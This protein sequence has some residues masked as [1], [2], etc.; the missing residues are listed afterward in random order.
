MLNGIGCF[1]V[2]F[3]QLKQGSKPYQALPR[4][5]AYTLQKPFEEEVK[6]L[7]KQDIIAHLGVDETVEWCN[8]FVLV[9]KVTGTVRLCLDTAWLNKM[10]IR[11]VHR[12]PTLND[13][14]PRLNAKYLSLIDV[15][16]GYHNLKLD[17]RSSYLMTFRC[18]FGRYRYKQLPFGAAL[19][20]N[21]FQS[22]GDKIFKE[23]LIVFGIADDI[24]VVRYEND[25]KDHD[26]ILWRVLQICKQ[27]NLKLNKDKCH[28][29]CTSVPFFGEVISWHTVKQDPQK[30]KALIKMPSPQSKKELQTFHGIINYFD[31]FSPNTANVCELLQKLMSSKTL[32]T[33]NTSYQALFDKVKSLIK[34]D[35]CMKFYDETKPCT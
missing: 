14:L 22:K 33:W 4:C 21:M 19:T 24:L 3:L 6:H 35:V 23:L 20:G 31:K 15:N 25:G 17:E 5:V 32:C 12:G 8:S 18:Q 11:L 9:P 2:T 1:D 7:Q 10:L 28:F 26:D 29:R 30:L 16:S 34:D 13:I 27:V